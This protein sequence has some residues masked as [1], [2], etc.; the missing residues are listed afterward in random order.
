[1][2]G[3]H[4]LVDQCN[5]ALQRNTSIVRLVY[6]VQALTRI[7]LRSE[8]LDQRQLLPDSQSF[9]RFKAFLLRVLKDVIFIVI[10]RVGGS[11]GD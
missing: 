3:F 2:G 6:F 9:Y 11:T 8:H 10:M 7:L 4:M 1:M 5:T